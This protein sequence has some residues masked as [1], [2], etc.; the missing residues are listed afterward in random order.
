MIPTTTG[1]VND[2]LK[3]F[4]KDGPG[5]GP[6]R[7]RFGVGSGVS[8]YRGRLLVVTLSLGKYKDFS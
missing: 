7:F 1:S 3:D 8:P 4:C 2:H 6:I 5:N